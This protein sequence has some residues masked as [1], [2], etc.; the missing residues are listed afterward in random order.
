[1]IQVQKVIRNVRFKEKDND[2]I[3][4]S[5]YDIIQSL[6]EVLRYLSMRLS[7]LN[8]DFMEKELV[9]DEKKIN[10]DIAAYNAELPEG[11]EPK[12]EV[13]FPVTGVELPDDFLSLMGVK[14]MRDDYLLKCIPSG[15]RLHHDE[16][17][18]MGNKL[19]VRNHAVRL[20]YRASE[21]GDVSENTDTI[22]L[23]DFFF[24]SLAKM[25]SM[26]LHNEANTDVLSDA[27]E[28]E[29]N[30]M[31]PRRR[32]RNARITPQFKV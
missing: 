21:I 11:E 2:E 26:V 25:T 10:E 15:N 16:Y 28:R 24:D 18:I 8:T 4:Y 32:Y 17:Y 23:P 27:F 22:A 31:I 20:L 19:Y 13:R 12:E 3:K 5:D 14:R 6:N 7:T 9:L 29:V 1:M 30:S